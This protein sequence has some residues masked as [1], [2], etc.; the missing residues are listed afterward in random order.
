MKS[1]W[2]GFPVVLSLRSS[3]GSRRFLRKED[4][5]DVGED[6]TLGNGHSAQKIVEFLI[7][8][9]SKLDVTRDDP[10]LLVVPGSVPGQLEDLGS[11]VLHDGREEDRSPTS[12]PLAVVSLAEMA[13]DPS[14]REL[15]S[16]PAGSRL[17]LGFDF[18]GFGNHLLF[19][20][21]GHDVGNLVTVVERS[22]V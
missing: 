16:G 22:S 13:M 2:F 15:E 18:G 17:R 10:D 1:S 8:P 21:V 4:W 3:G 5:I 19:L 11:E 6:A 7:V 9:H 20:V 14:N 12:D